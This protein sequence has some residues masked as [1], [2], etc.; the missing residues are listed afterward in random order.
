M[1]D[2]FDRL[3]SALASS[4]TIDQALGDRTIPP[5]SVN[6]RIVDR[7]K[8]LGA[9]LL[10]LGAIIAVILLGIASTWFY[11]L[12][13]VVAGLSRAYLRLRFGVKL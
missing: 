11:L 7:L 12:I 4:R 1:T 3:K 8:L 2:T 9:A 13:L 10:F 5:M 6:A